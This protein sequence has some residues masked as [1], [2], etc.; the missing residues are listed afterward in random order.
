MNRAMKDAARALLRRLP[1]S[2]AYRLIAAQFRRQEPE[3]R[4][5]AAFVPPDRPAVD[6]GAWWGPWTYWLSRHVP[7]VYAFEPQPEP[8]SFLRRVSGSRVRVIE[9]ALADASGEAELVVPDSAV[10]QD[11]L[12]HLRR[13][14]GEVGAVV[15]VDLKRLDDY[16]LS[17]AG[18]IKID[19]E[20]HELAV[21]R[22][23]AQTLARCAPVIFVEIEQRHSQVP[24]AE[25]FDYLAQAG[26]A[27]AYRSHRRWQPLDTFDVAVHQAR[28]GTRE[29]VNNFLFRPT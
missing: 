14:S 4:D 15:R 24:M 11:A 18:F 19:V 16:E 13:V 27:G 23:A 25:T 5:L 28:P 12:A 6:V 1:P 17:D 8:A 3:L 9:A 26:Y 21:L 20:G 29:Y 22:G 10:G 2:L 7:L